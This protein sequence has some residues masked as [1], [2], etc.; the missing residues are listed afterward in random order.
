VGVFMLAGA[1]PF[2]EIYAW[3]V[4]VGTVGVLVL[5]AAVALVVVVFFRRTGLDRRVWHTI[6][7]PLLG[8]AGLIYAIVM[9]LRHFEVLTG[10]TSDVVNGLY[11]LIPIVAVVGFGVGV[12]RIREGAD[13]E[14]GFR[15]DEPAPTAPVVVE[16]PVAR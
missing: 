14:R 11:W 1:D 3:L 13:L 5:Q 8:A 6:V 4:G 9:A 10:S 12:W 2:A 7:A 15:G 16:E